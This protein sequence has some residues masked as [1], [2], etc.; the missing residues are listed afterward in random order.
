M[1]QPTVPPTAGL[2]LQLGDLW[3]SGA[4]S[5]AG[6]LAAWLGVEAVQLECSGTSAL[7]VALRSLKTL[8]PGAAR[9]LHRP[10]PVRWWRWRLRS[11]GCSCACAICAPMR[12][13]WTRSACSACAATA[14]AVLPT[15]LCGRVADVDAALQCARAVG[16]YVIED[17]AQALGRA[18]TSFGGLKGDIGP[19]WPSARD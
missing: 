13:T 8:S 6:Q 5:L 14:L 2:P 18:A 12:W 16:A 10:I 11:A 17:A 4:G 19:A 3:P 1:R 15:H 7:M 9:S